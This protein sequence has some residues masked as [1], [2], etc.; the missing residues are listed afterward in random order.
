MRA[1]I[2]HDDYRRC[3]AVM[4]EGAVGCPGHWVEVPELTIED[5]VKQAIAAGYGRGYIRAVEH[6]IK[7]FF[8]RSIEV[9]TLGRKHLETHMPEALEGW[10]SVDISIRDSVDPKK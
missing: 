2:H 6:L 7:N 3:P 8:L 1:V 4:E 10:D 5:T 9:R